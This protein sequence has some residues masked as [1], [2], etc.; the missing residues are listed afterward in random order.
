[1]RTGQIS[2]S[3][4]RVVLEAT[5]IG[6]TDETLVRRPFGNEEHVASVVTPYAGY[7]AERGPKASI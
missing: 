7:V 1:M 6:L 2:N 5:G 3:I 4:V